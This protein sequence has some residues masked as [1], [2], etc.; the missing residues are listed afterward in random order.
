MSLRDGAPCIPC[1]GAPDACICG[2]SRVEALLFMLNTIALTVM[3]VM[4]LRDERRPPGT[5]Q[6]SVFRTFDDDD[7]RPDDR[8]EQARQERL[9]RSRAP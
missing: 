5:P 3:I 6:R 9:A 1:W 2:V 4:G 7:V 8:A